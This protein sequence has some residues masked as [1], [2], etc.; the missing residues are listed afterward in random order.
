MGPKIAVDRVADARRAAPLRLNAEGSKQLAEVVGRDR[1]AADIGPGGLIQRDE[2]GP[3]LG[4]REKVLGG[5]LEDLAAV[6][7]EAQPQVIV[8]G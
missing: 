6:G 2:G 7:E 1:P 8:A 5:S 4:R 3:Q